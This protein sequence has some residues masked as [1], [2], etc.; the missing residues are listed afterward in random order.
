MCIVHLPQFQHI[1]SQ[2]K[3]LAGR[4]LIKGAVKL[5]TTILTSGLFREHWSW[6]FL[7]YGRPNLPGLLHK[8]FYSTSPRFPVIGSSGYCQYRIFAVTLS[9]ILSHRQFVLSPILLVI[10]S[11]MIFHAKMYFKLHQVHTQYSVCPLFQLL[12][13]I[14][15]IWLFTHNLR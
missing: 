11:N 5:P 14:F 12:F 6:W 15:P 10:V 2:V 13:F 3:E 7:G 9:P 1:V 4:R 8:I